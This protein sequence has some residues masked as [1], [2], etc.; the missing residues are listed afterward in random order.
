LDSSS[1]SRS[2]PHFSSFDES[3]VWSRAERHNNAC[4]RPGAGAGEL[5]GSQRRHGHGG[6]GGSHMLRHWGPG[7]GGASDSHRLHRPAVSGLTLALYWVFM[8][9][10]TS[11][12]Q[13]HSWENV[14]R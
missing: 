2:L 1:G 8:T 3:V 12:K 6:T 4:R 7:H 10:I 9:S 11:G 14:V 5:S 13:G